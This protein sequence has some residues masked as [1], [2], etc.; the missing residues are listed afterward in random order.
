MKVW[1][2]LF[3]SSHLFILYSLLASITS[4][5]QL[6]LAEFIGE[7][8]RPNASQTH[9]TGVLIITYIL[10]IKNKV[11]KKIKLDRFNVLNNF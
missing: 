9:L 10:F 5:E 7:S 4:I 11:K 2:H 6:S 8:A 3:P 1:F